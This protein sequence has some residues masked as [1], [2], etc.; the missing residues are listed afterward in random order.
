MGKSKDS[1]T[2]C[3]L[4]KKDCIKE[5]CAWFMRVRGTNPNTGEPIDEAACAVAWM[6]YM[7]MDITQ[8]TNQAGAAVESFRNEVVKAN[9][10]N[11]QLYIKA[12][13]HGVVPARV[14]PLQQPINMLEESNQTEKEKEE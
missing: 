6:P 14:A 12:L 9:Q 13:T 4:I 7:A 5:K 2:F 10:S 8:K 3:P 11:Q 1:G